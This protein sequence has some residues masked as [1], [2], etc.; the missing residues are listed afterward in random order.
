MKNLNRLMV[1]AAVFSLIALL[2]LSPGC[3]SGKEVVE[4]VTGSRAVKQYHEMKKDTGKI[5]EQQEA[6][7]GTIPGDEEKEGED[8]K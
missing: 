3:D 6:R 7:Y 8:T 1:F 2:F 4:E 5:A